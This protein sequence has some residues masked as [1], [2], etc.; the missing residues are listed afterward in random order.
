MES[1]TPRPKPTPFVDSQIR[2]R[3]ASSTEELISRRSVESK[4]A[5]NA[6][7]KPAT[8]FVPKPHLTNRPFQDDEGLAALQ[9]ELHSKE[10]KKTPSTRAGRRNQRKSNSK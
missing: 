3:R 6:V 7:T 1:Q 2:I 5:K 8:P 9:K 4:P 10:T